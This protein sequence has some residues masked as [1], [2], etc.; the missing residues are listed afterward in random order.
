[1]SIIIRT[2]DGVDVQEGDRVFN[3]YDGWWG[4]ISRVDDQGW[5]NLTSRDRKRACLNGERV[6]KVIPPGNPFY[7][8]ADE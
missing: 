5:F 2:A 6:C 8:M 4:E 7:G 1:M 3:Y